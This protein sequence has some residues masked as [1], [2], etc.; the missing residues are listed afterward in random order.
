MRP[1]SKSIIIILSLFLVGTVSSQ[2]IQFDLRCSPDGNSYEVYVVRD[3]DTGFPFVL[4][5]STITLVLPTA[6]GSRTISPV[7]ESVSVYTQSTPIIDANGTG[8]DIYPF[9][10]SAGSL[11]SFTAN[12]PVLWLTLTPS[13]GTDQ[14]ARH[15]INGSDPDNFG[16]IV[17]TNFF[18]TLSGAP[19]QVQWT[20]IREM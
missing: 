9:D 3:A 8:I 2:N 7:S 15:F 13:D 20:S 17:P 10:G 6:G 19:P 16:S 18:A 14:E 11:T 5:A 4:G 12:T 1:I